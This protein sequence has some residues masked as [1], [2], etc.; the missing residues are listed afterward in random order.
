MFIESVKTPGIAHL[1]YVI[2][3]AGEACVIDPQL[4][5]DTYL[6]IAGNHGCRITCII[7]TH[8]NEDFVSGALSLSNKTQAPVYHGDNADEPVRYASTV[9]DND[10]IKVGDWKIVVMATPGHTKDSISLAC[11]D[12]SHSETLPIGVFTG[13]TLFVNDVGRTDFYP[14]EKEHMASELYDSLKKLSAL[15]DQVIV[16]PAHGA[17]SVCGG[18]MAD[19]EF[20]TIGYENQNNPMMKLDDKASFIRHK[21]NEHHYVSPYFTEMEQANV[22]GINAPVSTLVIQPVKEERVNRW[23]D[24]QDRPGYLIDI[25]SHAAFRE[26]HIPGSINLPGDLLS[27]YGGWLLAYQT[28]IAFVAETRQQAESATAQLWRM[29]FTD[30]EGYITDIPFP[31]TEK[32]GAQQCISTVT[33]DVVER[34]LRG[35]EENWV[36]L[37]VRKRDEVDSMA[38]PGALHTYLGHLKEY[39]EKLNPDIHY[40]CMCGSGKRATV[41]ASY[42]RM[43]GVEHVDVFTGSLQAWNKAE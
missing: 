15:G 21:V 39:R 14:E 33:A 31:V 28:P 41:A 11:Y 35:A 2:G 16:Y 32:D 36:L 3:N 6:N 17:G 12:T 20:T 5:S 26:N 1:S 9:K 24:K 29:G 25:R 7:E 27:A 34:K 42:L 37:D 18:G 38:F 4:D 40:T 43:L 8:R 10:V 22:T 23:L 13:D 19:R 30:I